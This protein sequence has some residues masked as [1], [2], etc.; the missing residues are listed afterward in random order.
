[1]VLNFHS[2]VSTTT[3]S[4]FKMYSPC[5][6]WKNLGYWYAI[7]FTLY[8]RLDLIWSKFCPCAHSRGKEPFLAKKK[9]IMQ[10]RKR[11]IA[12]PEQM[13]FLLNKKSLKAYDLL[14][15]FLQYFF[16]FAFCVAHTDPF[17]LRKLGRKIAIFR[18]FTKFCL[19]ATGLQLKLLILI[20][21][22]N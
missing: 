8:T 18:G 13:L 21:S 3:T 4:W 17:F 9:N 22:S 1:M 11:L 10:I 7:L 15:L 19:G 12:H 14:L 5:K 20:E 6:I 2:G 16:V